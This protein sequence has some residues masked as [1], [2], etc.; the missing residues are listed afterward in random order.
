MSNDKQWQPKAGDKGKMRNGEDYEILYVLPDTVTPED[1]YRLLVSSGKTVRWSRSDGKY[2]YHGVESDYDLL[3]PQ[4]FV[5]V[6]VYQSPRADG[7]YMSYTY[8]N[9]SDA[10]RNALPDAEAVAVAI[11]VKP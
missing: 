2:H 7:A 6:N 5:Y 9:K 4:K 1:R 3:P 11:E 10:E 8:T